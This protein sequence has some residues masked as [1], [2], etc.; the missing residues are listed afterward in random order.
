MSKSRGVLGCVALASVLALAAPQRAHAQATAGQ[1]QQPPQ[2]QAQKPPAKPEEQKPA[3][4]PPTYEETVVVTATKVETALVNAP[5]TISVISSATIEA[6]PTQGYAELL[7]AVPGTN[8]SQTSA[9]D[10]NITTRGATSTLSTSQLALIDGRSLYL[11]FFG[12]VA[13]DFLPVN[14]A[15]VKQIEIV[16]GPASAV[17]GANALTGVVNIITKS[18]REMQGGS[19]VVGFGGFDR[20]V[21]G[22]DEGTGS[23]FYLNGTWA[24]APTDKWSYKVS[25]GGFTMDAFARP[26]GTVPNDFHTPYP[27]FPNS[28]TTQPKF[29]T[30]VDYDAENGSRLVLAGGL[31]GTEGI[32]H[33]GIGPFDIQSGSILGYARGGWSKGGLKVNAFMNLL[34][35]DAPALLSVDATTGKPV[36]FSFKNQTY[37]VEFGNV[38]AIGTSHVLSYGGNVR[39][40]NFDLSI[41]P[42]DDNRSEIGGYIQDEIFF[43]DHFRWLVGARLDKFSVLEDPVFSPR[44]TFMIK[45]TPGQTFRVSYNRAYRAPSLINNFLD[46]TIVNQIDLGLINPLLAGRTYNFPVYATGNQDLVETSM[47]AYE[48]GYTGV[49]NNRASIS[50][51]FYV[52]DME[53]D[54]FFTQ[55]GSYSSA[56]P[57]PGWP[58][59]PIVLDLLIAAGAF[60][61]GNGLPSQFSYLNLGEVR[62]K[63]VELGFDVAVNPNV[64]TFANYS[65]QAEP[66]PT[67]F[68][69]SE[70][71]LP[72][73]SRF[74]VGVN[75]DYPRYMGS[76]SVSYTDDAYWQDVLDARYHGPTE[77]FTMV[78]GSIGARFGGGHVTTVLKLT[79]MFNVE[80]QQH[81]FGDILKRQIA[82]ELRVGF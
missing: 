77:A 35:G 40:N 12:F 54:I 55:V 68:D 13:W 26:T 23:L 42:G 7:R 57:P 28:G 53:D 8:V 82:G 65:Y 36:E 24:D 34:D 41:A 61:P 43:G 32:I 72:P 29:D 11:D 19:L 62:N 39:R 75:F 27:A 3:E 50:V 81:V 80:A 67:G 78:N 64:S 44:T 1:A 5:A 25:A 70:L 51:A 47:D 2:G 59:P 74:N 56:N 21:E 16:R 20:K 46:L 45:P 10:I 9:R 22:S 33:T 14:L 4:R 79:N 63:G 76:L 52:N 73:K 69:V 38:Q 49:I 71:N 48:I 66:V 30:R 18:P 15:E 60:G 31:A 17:W 37:D 58:L 6:S